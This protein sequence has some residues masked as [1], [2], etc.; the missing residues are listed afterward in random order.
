MLK[1]DLEILVTELQ[2]T[3][4]ELKQVNALLE[5][6]NHQLEAALVAAQAQVNNLKAM[7]CEE[8][9]EDEISA[10]DRLCAE[11]KITRASGCWQHI[12][13]NICG[14]QGEVFR[15]FFETEFYKAHIDECRKFFLA[16]RNRA[17]QR[18]L[19]AE[20]CRD[21]LAIYKK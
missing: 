6:Q 18:N 10:L 17:I 11:L 9:Q 19:Q 8:Q 3:V 13:V 7:G 14:T 21:H 2:V 20:F 12:T 1:K 16:L 15:V 5:E 4:T